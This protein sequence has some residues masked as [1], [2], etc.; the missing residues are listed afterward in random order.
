MVHV[1]KYLAEKYDTDVAAYVKDGNVPSRKLLESLG[2]KAQG[3]CS[4]VLM[5]IN[6]IEEMNHE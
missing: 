1:A 5:S 3:T 2:Y 4:W 6:S